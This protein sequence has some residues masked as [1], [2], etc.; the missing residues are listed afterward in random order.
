MPRQFNELPLS[1]SKPHITEIGLDLPQKRRRL[2][3]GEPFPILHQRPWIYRLLLPHQRSWI[4]RLPIQF[5]PPYLVRMLNQRHHISFH[6]L[7][8]L[9]NKSFPLRSYSTSGSSIFIKISH[10]H[11]LIRQ[12]LQILLLKS[13]KES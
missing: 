5:C 8:S 4:Y 10:S 3:F 13:N 11:R 2:D 9:F 12:N 1:S 6:P 7:F